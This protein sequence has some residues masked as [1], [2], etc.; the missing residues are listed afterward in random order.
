MTLNQ[1]AALVL[2]LI[3]L[4]IAALHLRRRQQDRCHRELDLGTQGE[5]LS[6]QTRRLSV[7][8]QIVFVSLVLIALIVAV[9]PWGM[10]MVAVSVIP[11][12]VGVYGITAI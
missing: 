1:Q 6:S 9:S 11:I 5:I 4:I 2:A 8:E 7:L 10:L 12:V 3:A